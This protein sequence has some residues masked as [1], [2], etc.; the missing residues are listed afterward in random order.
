MSHDSGIDASFVR[1]RTAL[2]AVAEHVLA[3]AR[4]QASG[5]LG[6]TVTPNGFA[7]PAFGDDA[8]TLAVEG[9]DLVVRVRT[10]GQAPGTAETRAPLRTLRAAATLVGLTA[11]GGPAEVYHLSSPC[12]PDAELALDAAAARR[13]ADWY[14]LGDTALHEWRAEIPGDDPSE[15]ALWPEHADVAIR[16]GDINY[17]ASL[18]D[19]AVAEPYLYVGPPSPPPPTPD[20]F[21]NASFGAYLTWDRVH[22]VADALDFFRRG[23]QRVRGG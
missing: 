1:T 23:R 11:P 17:G 18:G 2:H 5:R 21:W 19:E 20:G 9:T 4:Y 7:T 22:S 6:L 14:A 10:D 12:D 13:I 15:I 8:R 3:A 16:A